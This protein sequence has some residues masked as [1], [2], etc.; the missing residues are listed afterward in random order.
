MLFHILSTEMAAAFMTEALQL[1]SVV[2]AL[3]F[4][5]PRDKI[6]PGAMCIPYLHGCEFA[7][8]PRAK[9]GQPVHVL[10]R[11][12]LLTSWLACCNLH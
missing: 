5:D 3:E 10:L 4:L 2:P 8:Y 6:L 11:D 1:L 9:M 7:G 12:R